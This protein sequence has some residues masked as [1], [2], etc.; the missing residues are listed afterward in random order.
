MTL[1]LLQLLESSVC[2]PSIW[3]EKREERVSNVKEDRILI[4]PQTYNMPNNIPLSGYQFQA[5]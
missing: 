1:P 4:V 5:V 3:N 2:G